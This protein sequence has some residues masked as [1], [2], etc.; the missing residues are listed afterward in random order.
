MEDKSTRMRAN[1]KEI[2]E[3]KHDNVVKQGRCFFVTYLEALQQ[4]ERCCCV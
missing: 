2:G 3:K 1:W 4:D